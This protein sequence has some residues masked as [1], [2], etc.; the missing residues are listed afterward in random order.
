MAQSTRQPRESKGSPRAAVLI[1]ALILALSVCAQ[2]EAKIVV[3]KGAAGV[4]LGDSKHRV[5]NPDL[6]ISPPE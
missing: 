1:G 3:G 4:R 5:L 2:A 6:A